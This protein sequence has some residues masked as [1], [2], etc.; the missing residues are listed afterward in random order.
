[1][2]SMMLLNKEMKRVGMSSVIKEDGGGEWWTGNTKPIGDWARSRNKSV[3]VGVF[4]GSPLSLYTT[5]CSV[6]LL[7]VSLLVRLLFVLLLLSVLLLLWV[8]YPMCFAIDNQYAW[9]TH[10]IIPFSC[11]SFLF[12]WSRRRKLW[13]LH[14]TLCQV[15]W[16]CWW[17]FRVA[18]WS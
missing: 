9:L 7:L 10:S 12:H 17:S 11:S 16:W 3:W 8:N 2:A 1:M 13:I 4:V 5:I 15:L 14:W 18:T 6:L